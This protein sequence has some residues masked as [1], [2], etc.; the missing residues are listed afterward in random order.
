MLFFR[1]LNR[2][3]T[4]TGFRY[5]RFSSWYATHWTIQLWSD[6]RCWSMAGTKWWIFIN[7]FIDESRSWAATFYKSGTFVCS[8]NHLPHIALS[9]NVSM[10]CASNIIK[11][12]LINSIWICVIKLFLICAFYVMNDVRAMYTSILCCSMQTHLLHSVVIVGCMFKLIVDCS[13]IISHL[14][15]LEVRVAAVV[16][17]TAH[18]T[19]VANSFKV[20]KTERERN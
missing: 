13:R 8:A 18:H 5:L 4:R 6:T 9:V 10:Q 20:E 14:L 12:S 7:S 1:K 16:A 11:W 3:F 15:S 19:F 2:S 17:G